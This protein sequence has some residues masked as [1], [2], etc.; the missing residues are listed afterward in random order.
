MWDWFYNPEIPYVG[1]SIEIPFKKFEETDLLNILNKEFGTRKN[2]KYEETETLCYYS[3]VKPLTDFITLAED[4]IPTIKKYI[5]DNL[6]TIYDLN[7]K[8]P[9]LFK[10]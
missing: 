9:K 10:K 1:I 7:D 2:W 5:M 8:Y 4:N 6:Q 3:A